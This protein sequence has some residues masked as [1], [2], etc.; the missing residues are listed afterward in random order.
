[1]L[2]GNE[3]LILAVIIIVLFY[4]P[5][6]LPGLAQSVAKSIKSFKK[7]MNTDDEEI[8]VTASTKSE[9]LRTTEGSRVVDKERERDEV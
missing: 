7:A 6:R 1:M 8:D 3:I 4:A 9:K 2:G 5:S